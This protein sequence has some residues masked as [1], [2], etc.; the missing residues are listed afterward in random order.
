MQGAITHLIAGVPVSELDASIDWY[1]R[2]FGRP[3][4]LRTGDEILD[5]NAIA[6]AGLPQS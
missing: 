1:S 6:L 2:L 3:P 5:G 4:D